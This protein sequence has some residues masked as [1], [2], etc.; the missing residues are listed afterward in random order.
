MRLFLDNDIILK[1]SSIDILQEIEQ[2]YSA[3][4]SSIYILGSAKHYIRNS[5]SVK[6]KYS[7]ETIEN[8]LSAI[9]NYSIIPDDFLDENRLIELS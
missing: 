7:K 1:L 9:E 6:K 4:P 3:S 2:I 5:N 8:A